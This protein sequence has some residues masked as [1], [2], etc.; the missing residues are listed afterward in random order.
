MQVLEPYTIGDQIIQ[1]QSLIVGGHP[2]NA[3]PNV[4][5]Y[6]GDSFICG[7]AIHAGLI[8]D[9][10][11]GAGIVRLIGER[12]DFPSTVSNGIESI[13]FAPQFPLSFTFEE[14]ARGMCSDPRWIILGL[15]IA[16]TL[17]LVLC[18]PSPSS[19]FGA[20]FV[21]AY[22][23]I[24]LAADAPEPSSYYQVVSLAFRGFLPAAFT[25]YVVY[26]YCVKRTL[27]N[28]KAPF[29]MIIFW[30]T[31]F[32]VGALDNLTFDKLPLQRLTPH[33]LRQPG[34]IVV[35][36]VIL[37]F[38]LAA[39]IGQILGFRREGRL[40]RYLL[41]YACIGGLLLFLLL[42][43][44]MNL[45]LHH[46]IIALILLPGTAIQTRPSLIYQ[47][48][49]VGLFINGIARWGFDSILQTPGELFAIDPNDLVPHINTPQI[50]GNQMTFSWDK[51]SSGYDSVSV[52]VNDV[53]RYRGYE[54]HE[55]DSFSWTKDGVDEPTYLRF[56][57]VKYG[58][59]GKGSVGRY[60][61]TGT[62]LAN[63]TWLGVDVEEEK[64]PS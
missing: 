26:K 32:W 19:F 28:L 12:S 40:R 55:A 57:Y 14:S 61:R 58:K 42:I 4:H 60:S 25:G 56:G 3:A 59:V 31:P 27:Q 33:D 47:G 2:A 38:I 21:A 11:G 17:V 29:D 5:F 1:Y 48:L 24:A 35:L 63:G 7:A 46:Y 15:T 36:I 13:A 9:H 44:N 50:T 53:E 54:D 45:R 23:C 43:P 64:R 10:F 37:S 30:V 6:R 51:L 16:Y 22:F 8:K 41:L 49:L 20:T 62:W 18:T 52:L 39:A 34:A